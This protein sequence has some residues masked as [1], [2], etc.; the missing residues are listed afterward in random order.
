MDTEKL[1]KEIEKQREEMTL[2]G[3]KH[4]L[5]DINTVKSSQELDRLLNVLQF[6]NK[7]K[8]YRSN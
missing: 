2:L 7:T 5:T 8:I 4:G 3:L 6:S 1:M